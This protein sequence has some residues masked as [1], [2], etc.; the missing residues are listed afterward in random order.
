MLTCRGHSFPFPNKLLKSIKI[1]QSYDHIFTATFF[2][3][4]QCIITTCSIWTLTYPLPTK[5]LFT[6]APVH[7]VVTYD[8]MLAR[9][10]FIYPSK[11]WFVFGW[12]GEK[13][14]ENVTQYIDST[15]N[16]SYPKNVQQLIDCCAYLQSEDCA[17]ERLRTDRSEECA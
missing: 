9:T 10:I 5:L 16:N 6:C 7:Y 13:A 2:N 11:F 12:N 4:S 14:K 8:A 1:F 15:V 17:S 3:E